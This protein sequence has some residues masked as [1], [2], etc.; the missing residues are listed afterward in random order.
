MKKPQ[1]D[2]ELIRWLRERYPNEHPFSPVKDIAQLN[3]DAGQQSIINLL[4][5]FSQSKSELD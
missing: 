4:E 5:R 1:V 2:P 3:F